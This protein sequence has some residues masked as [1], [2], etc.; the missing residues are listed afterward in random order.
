MPK[1]VKKGKKKGKKKKKVV[2]KKKKVVVKDDDDEVVVDEQA[3]EE[4][5]ERL[6]VRIEELKRQVSAL[7]NYNIKLRHQKKDNEKKSVEFTK[8]FERE[9]RARDQETKGN[10]FL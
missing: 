4:E 6:R 7:Q 9:I 5:E 3:E 1:K 8:Y 2:K 10:T